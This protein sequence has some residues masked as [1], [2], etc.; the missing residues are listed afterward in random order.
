MTDISIIYDRWKAMWYDKE[1]Y[2]FGDE[3][4]DLDN[5]RN[6]V[7]ETY[8]LVKEM[9]IKIDKCDYSGV[10]P[11]IMRDYIDLVSV[12]SLYAA[13]LCIDES[14]NHSFAVTRLLSFDL[15]DLG[16]NY[17]FYMNDKD[18]PLVDGIITSSE[19]FSYGMD[20][21][22]HYDINKGDLSEYEELASIVG[23]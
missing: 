18:E 22:T 9:H 11:K 13:P 16:A 10:S 1:E 6:L 4:V 23:C 21:E 8:S 3:K 12:I 17:S 15:A 20:H 19:G 2:A 5:F 14:E 7:R